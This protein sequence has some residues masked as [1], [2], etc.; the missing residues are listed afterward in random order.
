MDGL[1]YLA[2]TNFR[3]LHDGGDIPD[4]KCCSI[5]SLELS[6]FNVV[7]IAIEADFAH[8]DLLLPLLDEAAACVQVVVGQLLLNLADA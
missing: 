7:D 1:A 3:T 8:V 5:G 2:Q 4:L 6:L